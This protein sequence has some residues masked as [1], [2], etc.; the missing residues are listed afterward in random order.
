MLTIHKNTKDQR[1]SKRI[2]NELIKD[3]KNL[4]KNQDIKGYAIVVWDKN[5]G[6]ACSWD[7]GDSLPGIVIPEFTKQILTRR[8]GQDDTNYIID[9]R[10]N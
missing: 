3:A 10:F 1:E 5:Y 7:T 8:Q 2:R 4:A 6:S 9:E